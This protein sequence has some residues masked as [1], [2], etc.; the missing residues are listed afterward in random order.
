MNRIIHDAGAV[1]INLWTNDMEPQ[2]LQQFVAQAPRP[3]VTLIPGC[4]A[5][6]E[7]VFLSESGWDVT[8]IDFSAA[9]V[10]TARAAAGKWAERIVE[11]DFFSFQPARTLDMI[12][13]R[14]FLCALPPKMRPA[15]AARWAELLPSGGLL[16]GYFFFDNSPKGPPFGIA[17]Q[18]LDDLLL[19]AFELLEDAEVA[20]SI[21]AFQ[22]KERWKVWRRR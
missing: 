11:A 5:A 21:A 18:E 17:A 4:G 1:P 7:A 9:A 16:A 22:G 3:L 15:I 6:Y 12:Y 19:P 8:A 13:E 2:A 10:A 20:D 14:A